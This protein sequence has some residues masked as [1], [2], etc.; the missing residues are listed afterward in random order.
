MEISRY[1]TG[2]SRHVHIQQLPLI[3]DFVFCS[4]SYKQSTMNQGEQG[5]ILILFKLTASLV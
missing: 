1:Q 5:E 2:S 3:H 4:F